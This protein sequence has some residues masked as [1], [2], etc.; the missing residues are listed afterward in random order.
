M[1]L[2][3]DIGGTKF[4]VALF[5]GDRMVRR[6]S[7]PT[8]RAGGRDW[9][10]EQIVA[11]AR[12]WQRE[13]PFDAL[14]HRLWRTG[15][16]R[17]TAGGFL[18]PRRRLERFSFDRISGARAGRSRH[19]GQRRQCRRAGRSRVRRRPRLLAAVLH[20]ALDRHRRR[21]LLGRQNLA[22]RRWLGRRDRP[23]LHPSRWP[24]MPVQGPR[25]FRADVLRAMA[26]TRLRQDGERT[27]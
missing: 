24:R 6:E 9:M 19:H 25:L 18:H 7:R 22:R 3:I 15:R 11:I 16:F 21:H 4:A 17:P 1:T 2:A 14:R 20:D 13:F 5:D 12:E 10:L 23:S 26:G 27:A 8:D